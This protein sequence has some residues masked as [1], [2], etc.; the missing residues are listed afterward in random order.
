MYNRCLLTS[1]A[2]ININTCSVY[3]LI[4]IHVVYVINYYIQGSASR[5]TSSKLSTSSSKQPGSY[6]CH[7]NE[8]GCFGEY[9]VVMVI[10]EICACFTLSYGHVVY[11]CVLCVY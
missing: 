4:L 1:M 8:F 3:I 11:L 10:V 2:T 6:G 7:G 5:T 9:M